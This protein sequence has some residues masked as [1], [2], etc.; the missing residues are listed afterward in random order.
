LKDE[1]DGEE[2]EFED[3]KQLAQ[4]LFRNN[5][6]VGEEDLILWEFRELEKTYIEAQ[7]EPNYDNVRSPYQRVGEITYSARAARS[8]L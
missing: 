1:I 3:A 6:F 5:I 7:L 2:R 8:V 4:R